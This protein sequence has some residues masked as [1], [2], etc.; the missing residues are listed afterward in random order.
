MGYEL[1][2]RHIG[3]GGTQPLSLGALGSYGILFGGGSFDKKWSK[4]FLLRP[5]N[6]KQPL[7]KF[8]VSA[9]MVTVVTY[10]TP[11]GSDSKTITFQQS[12]TDFMALLILSQLT[13]MT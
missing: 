10:V 11:Q 2:E 6:E 13:A 4:L 5:K 9:I 1:S 3:I 8:F 7:S 12:E